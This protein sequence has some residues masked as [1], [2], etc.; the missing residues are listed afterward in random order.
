[1]TWYIHQVRFPVFLH[2]VDKKLLHESA[3]LLK[4]CTTLQFFFKHY[5]IIFLSLFL[6]HIFLPPPLTQTHICSLFA[7]LWFACSHRLPFLHSRVKQQVFLSRQ[8]SKSNVM[9]SLLIIFFR[10]NYDDPLTYPSEWLHHDK[11]SIPQGHHT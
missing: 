8:I 11:T 3:S 5:G 9:T 4:P 2:E 10:R 6:P 1:M 7:F